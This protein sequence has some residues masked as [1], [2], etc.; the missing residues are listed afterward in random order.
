MRKAKILHIVG[1]RPNFVKIAPLMDELHRHRSSFTQKLVHTGQ[2]YGSNMSDPF[3]KDLNIIRPDHNLNVQSGTHAVQTAKMMMRIE[4]ILRK[5]KPDLVVVVGDVNSTLAGALTASKLGIPLAHIESGLRSFDRA[6]PEEI[7][8]LLTD[9]LSSFLFTTS[10]EAKT[11]L[12]NEGVSE[13]NIFYTGNIMI[14]TLFKLR[15]RWGKSR[16][17]N[18]LGLMNGEKPM[19]YILLTLHRPSNVDDKKSLQEVFRALKAIPCHIPIVYPVHPRTKKSIQKLGLSG[20]MHQIVNMIRISPLGYLDFM[21]LMSK[22]LCV[23]T[24]SGG[25]Q[26]ETTVLDIPCLTLRSNT[27]RPITV[28]KGT[29]VLVGTQSHRMIKEIRDILDGKKKKGKIPK[30]WDGK[31]AKRIVNVLKQN[32]ASLI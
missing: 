31:S 7:N 13:S 20:Q 27:E 10:P 9:R 24:D 32:L 15:S 3:F 12:M 2:H 22:S 11:N 23:L 21:K 29:N 17:L 19:D 25:V 16:I 30:Y 8:R 14:D 28:T 5:Y 1:T 6:M 18:K 26:E 4:P